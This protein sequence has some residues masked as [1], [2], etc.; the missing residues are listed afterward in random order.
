MKRETRKNLVRSKLVPFV[1]ILAA[2]AISLFNYPRLDS[3]YPEFSD[4]EWATTKH[5]IV[6]CI[7]VLMVLLLV[8]FHFASHKGRSEEHRQRIKGSLNS[9]SNIILSLLLIIYIILLRQALGNENDFLTSGFLPICIG[10]PLMIVGNFLPLLYRS[11]VSSM[12]TS[13]PHTPPAVL[14]TLLKIKF[15][16][17]YSTNQALQIKFI[18][19]LSRIYY[20]GGLVILLTALLPA[21]YSTIGSISCLVVLVILMPVGAIQLRRKH[22]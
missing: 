9:I 4:L 8:L 16:G 5:F 19:L 11:E 1:L 3:Y 15:L 7:P 2:V 10:I 18:L 21:P 20:L 13:S 14:T 17:L 12:Q 6:S 22:R